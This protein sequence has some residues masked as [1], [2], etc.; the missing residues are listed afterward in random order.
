MPERP[1]LDYQVPLLRE[2]LVGRGV[3]GVTVHKPVVLRV[4]V[5]GTPQE[6]LVGRRF[7]DVVRRAHV[8]VMPMTGPGGAR[9]GGALSQA[10]VLAVAPM[11]AGRFVSDGKKRGD[12]ALVLELD[13]GTALAYADDVQ[14]GRVFLLPEGAPVPGA[15]KVGVDVRGPEFGEEALRAALKGRR[16]QIKLVLMDKT[17]LDAFGN[18]YADEALWEAQVHPKTPAN[19]LSPD[20]IRRLAVGMRKV[21]DHAAAEVEA[22]RPALHE[23]VRDFLEVRNRGG[24][25]CSRCGTTIRA[26]GAHGHDA[27]YCPRCQED[28]SGRGIV[29]WTKLGR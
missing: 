10:I 1:E 9:G 22:R 15:E 5:P 14:M 13:D 16:E 27:F 25:P 12:T 18:A 6:I 2:R 21:L 11:L 4:A 24:A 17:A 19:R 26:C 8:L 28:R 29:D 3:R 23:K 7:L 20:E